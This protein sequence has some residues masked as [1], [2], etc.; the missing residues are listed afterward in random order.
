M[1]KKQENH[2][3]GC[4]AKPA[5]KGAWRET[6]RP[7]VPEYSSNR[8]YQLIHDEI[9]IKGPQFTQEKAADFKKGTDLLGA[10]FVAYD[11]FKHEEGFERG[12]FS[13]MMGEWMFEVDH[14]NSSMGQF[15]TP[16]HICD[17]MTA[18]TLSDDAAKLLEKPEL[19]MDPSAGTG[20]FMLSTAKHY[21]KVCGCFNFIYMNIDLDERCYIY[22]TMNA[23]LNGIP[24]IHIHGNSLSCDYYEAI[25]VIPEYGL[26]MW[27]IADHKMLEE[28]EKEK[29]RKRAEERRAEAMKP[30]EVETPFGK[31][32]VRPKMVD[33]ELP[34]PRKKEGEERP[35]Q[36]TL[37]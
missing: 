20:R 28:R 22:S 24:S 6:I 29:F 5:K 27:H 32:V 30:R 2:S 18:I 33:P 13:D 25:A 7:F 1:S 23:I 34:K 35:R 10:L 17:C 4:A 37:G 8:L 19:M 14:F 11:Q 26:P 36:A 12:D 15:F 3:V 21:A 9:L 16:M 31:A